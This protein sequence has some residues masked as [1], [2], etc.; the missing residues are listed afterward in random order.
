MQ[1]QPDFPSYFSMLWADPAFS[2]LSSDNDSSG[3]L[4]FKDFFSAAGILS[5]DRKI[6][7][8]SSPKPFL[9]SSNIFYVVLGRT[10]ISH[11]PKFPHSFVRILLTWEFGTL[12]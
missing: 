4:F 1:D 10:E 2:F 6:R 12:R 11:G 7:S 8:L 3:Y 9:I 5:T